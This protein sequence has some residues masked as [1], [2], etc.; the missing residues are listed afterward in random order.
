[1]KPAAILDIGSAKVVCLCGSAVHEDG[2]LYC[3]HDKTSHDWIVKSWADVLDDQ[4]LINPDLTEKQ[5]EKIES[6][7]M[8]FYNEYMENPKMLYSL[9]KEYLTKLY[10]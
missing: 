2:I 3:Y 1:M 6:R 4:D 8:D 5:T 9:E 10:C 7:M